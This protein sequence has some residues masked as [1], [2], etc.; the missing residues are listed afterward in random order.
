M[1][2]RINQTLIELVFGDITKETT[3]AIVNAANSQLAGG[4]GV[5]GAIHAAG[6]PA[7]MA[8]CRQI[9]GCPT[10]QAVITTGG[11]LQA[12]FVIHT[13]GPVWH[14]GAQHE[15]Q[16]LKAAYQNSLQL[17][18]KNGLQSIA[19]P[20]ISCVVYGYPVHDAASIALSTCIEFA[21]HTS[22]LTLIRH[23]LFNQRIFDIYTRELHTIG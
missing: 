23:V 9:G 4:A 2:A 5:D 22:S 19:F 6:G 14:G 18:A 12:R 1:Q 16:L 21:Q 7:I 11:H 15:P 17:A 3:D 10:G 20:A 13:V 8:Q